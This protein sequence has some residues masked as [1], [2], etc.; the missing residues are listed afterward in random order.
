[1]HFSLL[2]HRVFSGKSCH[3]TDPWVPRLENK[4]G[5][6]DIFICKYK[7][8]ALEDPAYLALKLVIPKTSGNPKRQAPQVY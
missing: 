8:R 7:A 1:M 6:L 5:G 2:T 3:H 4:L